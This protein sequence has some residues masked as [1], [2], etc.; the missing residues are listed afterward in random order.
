MGGGRGKLF[1]P[2]EKSFPGLFIGL[3]LPPRFYHFI[4]GSGL[5]L[6]FNH[7]SVLLQ[8]CIEALHIK[9]NGKYLDGTVGGGGHSFE[10]AK[11]L[12]RGRLFCL[13]ADQAAIQKA[14]EVLRPFSD[15]VS[16]IHDNFRN[17]KQ[18]FGDGAL[19]ENGLDGVLL[20]LGVSSHQLDEA[21]RG[22]SYMQDAPLDMRMDRNQSLSAF[23][24][25]N[26]YAEDTLADI[27]F[28]YGEE[29]FARRIAAKIAEKRKVK[30][31]DSTGELVTIIKSAMPHSHEKQHPAKRSFQA[32]RIAVNN[33][34]DMLDAS[35]RD[36]IRCL[37]PG[38]RICVITF[39]S[40]EDRIVKTCFKSLQNPCT[41]PRELPYCVCGKTAELKV[42]TPKPI[43][44]SEDEI[45]VNPRARS[46]KLRVGE[47]L[48]RG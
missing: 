18:W 4:K 10:I 5:R 44:P 33:E 3:F 36:L 37:N 17:V 40:L 14:S 12:N 2:F 16:F 31:I 21:D 28:H 46:A 19:G 29:R 25:V 41:C 32:I 43:L 1:S 7:V 6:N 26:E 34:L 22:F 35:L 11:R 27:L 30:T 13:D 23:D 48:L 8:E 9:E 20:D 24:V 47:K 38:G 45:T 15:K 39:H 42:V